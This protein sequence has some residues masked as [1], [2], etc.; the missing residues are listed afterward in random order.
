MSFTAVLLTAQCRPG[1]IVLA[2]RGSAGP[3]M[4]TAVITGLASVTAGPKA[5]H[6][7]DAALA[8]FSSMVPTA[9]A[10]HAAFAHPTGAALVTAM[11]KDADRAAWTAAGTSYFFIDPNKVALIPFFTPAGVPASSQAHRPA[12]RPPQPGHPLVRQTMLI[13]VPT[14]T[15]PKTKRGGVS[16]E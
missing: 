5:A 1:N 8:G 2:T 16:T 7:A 11:P 10:L 3:L 6:I 14:T 15:P 9:H 4:A 13:S 12:L